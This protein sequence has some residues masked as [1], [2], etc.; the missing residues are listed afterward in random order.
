LP[1]RSSDRRGKFQPRS[2]DCRFLGVGLGSDSHSSSVIPCGARN[3][4]L[5]YAAETEERFLASLEMTEQKN[6]P[7]ALLQV[8][9]TLPQHHQSKSSAANN[10]L[11]RA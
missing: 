8:R 9:A 5:I 6:A 11:L 2:V 10:M 4:S 3:L 7:S 1:R